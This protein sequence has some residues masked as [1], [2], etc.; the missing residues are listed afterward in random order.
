[1]SQ[2]PPQ[3]PSQPPQQPWQQPP[4]GYQ[5]SP[6]WSPQQSG[7]FPPM[8]QPPQPKP[9]QRKRLNPIKLYVAIFIAVPLLC[10]IAA[11]TFVH[12][13]TANETAAIATATAAP[14]DTP[15]PQPSL[16]YQLA[17]IDAGGSLSSTDASIATYQALLDTLQ[18]KTGES[19]QTIAD[20]TVNGRDLV[21]SKYSKDVTLLVLLQQVDKSV[22]D[23]ATI[24]YNEALA[25]YITLVYS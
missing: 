22:P 8:Q 16:A 25:A 14:T 11:V 6:P 19:E 15:V 17:S 20:E 4:T 12:S 10:G 1:M 13:T 5:P 3:W 21:K 24:H 7:Q 23:G 9:P 18:R 2:Y